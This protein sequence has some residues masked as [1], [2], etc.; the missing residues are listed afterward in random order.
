MVT[1]TQ[2]TAQA[3]KRHIGITEA[4][5]KLGVTRQHLY[6]VIKGERRSPRIERFLK[7]NMRRAA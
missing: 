2:V 5:R 7:T 1:V 6:L 3:Q 4:A